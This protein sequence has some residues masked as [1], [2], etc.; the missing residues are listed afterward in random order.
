MNI[1]FYIS[2]VILSISALITT[3]RIIAGPYSLDRLISTDMLVA[4]IICGLCLWCV[5][6]QQYF[7][8]PTIIALSLLSFI[9]STTVA[10][11]RVADDQTPDI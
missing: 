10:R 4:V 11:Y 8:V 1:I 2:A 6:R 5:Y 9:G 7:L 3:Y